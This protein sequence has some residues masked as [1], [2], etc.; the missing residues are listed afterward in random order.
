M[1]RLCSAIAA[2]G[3]SST[4]SVVMSSAQRIG[5]SALVAVRRRNKTCLSLTL[6]VSFLVCCC[7]SLHAIRCPK[8]V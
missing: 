2:S 1:E 6:C 5:H 4:L 7:D 3:I 8:G